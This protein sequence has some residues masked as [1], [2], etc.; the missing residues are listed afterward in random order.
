MT[1]QTRVLLGMAIVCLLAG[2]V[3]SWG[4][5]SHQIPPSLHVLF[6][7]GT[8]LLGL[9]LISRLF[10]KEE[11]VYG[12]DQKRAAAKKGIRADEPPANRT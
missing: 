3:L 9:F 11:N 6:P 2:T 12:D 7:A 5:Y 1:L 4:P 10:S 8:I